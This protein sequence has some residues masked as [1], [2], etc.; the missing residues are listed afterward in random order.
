MK[1]RLTTGLFVFCGIVISICVIAIFLQQSEITYLRQHNN[2]IILKSSDSESTISSVQEVD[3]KSQYSFLLK[4]QFFMDL[5][6][7][8]LEKRLKLSDYASPSGLVNDAVMALKIANIA[9]ETTADNNIV[10]LPTHE[11]KHDA[12]LKLWI[13][14]YQISGQPNYTTLVVIDQL[15]GEIIDISIPQS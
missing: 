10:Y 7:I 8:C 14:E 3:F 4:N 5:Y 13:V 2:P 1:K 6:D 11:I 15:D 9:I 12:M